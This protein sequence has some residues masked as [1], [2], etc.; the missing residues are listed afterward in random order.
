MKINLKD[1][2]NQ[3]FQASKLKN[4]IKSDKELGSNKSGA[5]AMGGKKISFGA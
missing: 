2:Y 3:K 4:K 5:L 1:A